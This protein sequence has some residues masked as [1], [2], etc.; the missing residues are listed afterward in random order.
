MSRPHEALGVFGKCLIERSLS[1]L[2]D[3]DVLS[4]KCLLRSEAGRGT[5]VMVVVVPIDVILALWRVESPQ[6]AEGD[7]P[8]I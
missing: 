8:D 2:D 4:G 7:Q 5:V 3:V 1:D 6:I